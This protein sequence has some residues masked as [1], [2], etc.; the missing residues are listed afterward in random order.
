MAGKGPAAG[1]PRA[2]GRRVSVCG[3]GLASV[4]EA[5]D[6]ALDED[7]ESLELHM[8]RIRSIDGLSRLS[9]LTEL[10]LSSNDIGRI[11]G[12]ATLVTLRT[13]NLSS[14]RLTRV[15][16]LEQQHWLTRLVLSYKEN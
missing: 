12:L 8:N 4:R 16:G 1:R 7:V 3:A 15:E 14:N 5:G 13:L 6:G 10:N 2:R 11:E 9:A